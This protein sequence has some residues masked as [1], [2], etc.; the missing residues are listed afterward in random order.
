MAGAL[1]DLLHLAIYLGIYPII[2]RTLFMKTLDFLPE[3]SRELPFWNVKK[4]YL[5]NKN[6]KCIRSTCYY[7]GFPIIPSYQP[8]KTS[9]SKSLHIQCI[10]FNNRPGRRRTQRNHIHWT[11]CTEKG[12]E[13]RYNG[14]FI[15]PTGVG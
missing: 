9:L 4:I 8:I 3:N 11:Y 7:G 14:G 15:V 13:I 6:I 5:S 10:N 2:T 1:I 12:V